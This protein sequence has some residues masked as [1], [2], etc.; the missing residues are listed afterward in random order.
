MTFDAFEKEMNRGF[1]Q[2][3]ILMVLETPLYGYMIIKAVAGEGYEV[4]ENS[5]YPLLRRLES[6]GFLESRW[7]IEDNKPRKYYVISQPGRRLRARLM[8]IW[9]LQHRVIAKFKRGTG[10]G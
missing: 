6:K 10:D 1:L 3:L 2:L 4:E 8:E 7:E 9:E 5:L